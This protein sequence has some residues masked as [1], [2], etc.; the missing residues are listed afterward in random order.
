ML[1]SVLRAAMV[2]AAILAPTW[3][4]AGGAGPLGLDEVRGGLALSD[5]ELIPRVWILPDPDS[6]YSARFDTA[7]VDLLFK[8]PDAEML[9]WLGSPRL[10]IGGLVSLDGYEDTLHAGLNWHLPLGQSPFFWEAGLGFGVHT[11]YNI[12]AP[13]GFRDLGCTTLFHY[14]Y[15]MGVNINEHLTAMLQFQ[16]MSSA[17][18]CAPNQG[19]NNVGFMLG[20]KF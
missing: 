8:L 6:F 4:F 12:D 10:D 3:A 11:G 19:I 13:P 2:I 16:H 14:D 7:Q 1:K 5:L 9:R 15:G 20:Y 17:D 18:L